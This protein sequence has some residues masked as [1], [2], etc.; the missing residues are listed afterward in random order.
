IVLRS[1]KDTYTLDRRGKS[2]AQYLKLIKQANRADVF[3][4]GDVF[5]PPRVDLTVEV[6]NTSDKKIKF[7]TTG[8]PVYIKLDLKGPG[9][10]S[11]P[12]PGLS[13]AEYRGPIP[14]T[15][16]P[17][18]S[19]SFKLSSLMYGDR[20]NSDGA[21]WTE[22]GDYTLSATLETGVSPK[23]KDAKEYHFDKT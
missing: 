18:K 13:S 15:L 20:G 19:Y 5:P 2:A 1:G 7:W 12:L 23:S 3:P 21:Y 16:G 6:R 10:Y 11:S 22:E 17:G 4:P 8:D 14:T 9:A